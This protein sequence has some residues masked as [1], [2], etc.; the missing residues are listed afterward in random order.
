VKYIRWQGYFG[1]E[2]PSWKEYGSIFPLLSG[3]SELEKE[4]QETK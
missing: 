2:H 1:L 3:L 4:N